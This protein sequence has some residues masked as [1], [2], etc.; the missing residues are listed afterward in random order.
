MVG[1]REKANT[2]IRTSCT[3]YKYASQE[4]FILVRE[5]SGN[6]QGNLPCSNC[7]HPGMVKHLLVKLA[8]ERCEKA[9]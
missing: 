9:N 8:P 5:K 6:C 7:G 3:K 4:K 1:C 2:D